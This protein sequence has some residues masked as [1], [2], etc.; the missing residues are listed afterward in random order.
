MNESTAITACIKYRD[1]TGFDY[2]VKKYRN[3]A[4]FHAIMFLG[5][6]EDAADACQESFTRAF[7]AFPKLKE[8]KNFYPWFYMILKNYCLNIIS[9][10]KILDRYSFK[11]K[12]EPDY[13]EG[14]PSVSIEKQE[15]KEMIRQVLQKLNPE[16]REILILK[17]IKDYKYEE[18]SRLL[19]IP[20]GTVMSRLYY[21]RKSF[22]EQ[23][24]QF[25]K[26]N[27]E[28]GVVS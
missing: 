5:N 22:R 4:Y 27:R 26:N 23:Y 8:L 25:N 19:N 15:E 13:Q 17:Y 28:K 20:R 24:L 21:A 11:S 18:I 9:R 1:P 16:F 3:E 2:L 10:K 14:N 6:N 12:E 7:N